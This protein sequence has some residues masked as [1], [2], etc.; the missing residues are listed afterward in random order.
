MTINFTDPQVDDLMSLVGTLPPGISITSQTAT[1]IVL[2][3]TA[4]LSN[5]RLAMQNVRFENTSQN[6]VL[7]DRHFT[8]DASD[9]S[10]NSNTATATISVQRVNDAP[11]WAGVDNTP[12]YIENGA[13]VVLDADATISD[14]ELDDI[15]NYN[16]A[17]LT[18]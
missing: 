2:G 14:I 4:T 11:V 12:T 6:A 17:T 10:F 5:Y 8:V 1:Q 9:G 15:N 13:P 3:G 18:L 7:A 16:G